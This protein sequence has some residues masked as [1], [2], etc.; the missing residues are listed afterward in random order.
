MSKK[1]ARY[2]S[3]FLAVSILFSGISLQITTAFA[4]E[5]NVTVDGTTDVITDNIDSESKENDS[6]LQDYVAYTAGHKITNKATVDVKLPL[7]AFVADGAE[8]VM[9][10]NVLEWKDGNGKV[11]WT[12]EVTQTAVYNLEFLW[13]APNK[14]IDPEFEILIDG[15]CPFDEAENI[16][17][18]RLWKNKEDKPR[19]DVQGNQYAQEQIEIDD[20]VSTVVRDSEGATVGPFEFALTAGTHTFTIVRPEQ[21]VNLHEITFAKPEV[22]KSYKDVS[23]SYKL[24]NLNTGIITIQ[25]EDA[26]VK[27]SNSIIPK[28]NNSDAG[29]EPHHDYLTKINYIGGTAWQSSGSRLEW[30]FEVEKSGYYYINMRYKQSDLVNGESWRWLKIDGATPFEEAMSLKFPYGTSWEYFT[31][32]KDMGEDEAVK[33]YYIYLDKGPHTISMEVTAGETAEYFHELSEI[34]D[35]L[36]DK[37]MQI[38]MITGESPDLSR[39]YDLDQQIPDFTKVLTECKDR[40]GTLADKMTKGTGQASQ[41]VSAMNNMKRVLENMLRSPYIA[42]QYVTD[43]YS[44]YSSIGS[45]LYDMIRM[46]LSIDE[47]QIIPKGKDYIDKEAGFFS[48]LKFDAV[49]LISSF[50]NDY[51]LTNADKD[52]ENTIRLWV[53]WGQDQA[54]AL[55][56]LIQDSF[57]G[58]KGKEKY[59][60][61]TDGDG[62]GDTPINVQVEIVNASLINGLLAD[63]F[64]DVSLQMART[65]PVNLGIRGALADLSEMPG[66]D[67]TIKQFQSGLTDEQI[68]A[69]S[70]EEFKEVMLTT[71]AVAPYTYNG[72]TYALPDTQNFMLMFYREDIL[73]ELGFDEPPQTWDEFLYYATIIQRKNMSVYVPYTQ[74]TT[75]TTVNAGIGNLHLYPTLMWQHG[76]NIYNEDGNKTMIAGKSELEVF[77]KWTDFYLEY[78]FLKEAD[79]YNRMR[80]GT[81]P[82]GIAPYTTYMTFY[83]TAPEIRGRW[84]IAKVPGV[85]TNGNGVIDVES[86]EGAVAGSGTGCAIIKESTKKE[87]AWAFLKWWTSAETQQRYNENLQSILGMIGRTAVSNKEAFEN[88]AWDKDDLQLLKSQWAE[89]MEVQEVPGSYDV[90]RAI[91]QAFWSVLEDKA[92][93]KDA[94]TKWSKIADR[95]IERKINEYK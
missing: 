3:V 67:E 27:T 7:A 20:V 8:I 49:R 74:I 15:V 24:Q 9:G 45:W 61:D 11:T 53:N 36:G 37:Y 51:S 79:F 19:E 33:P 87:Q 18:S 88:L 48:Q 85:D 54:A 12:F 13:K 68:A 52:D 5:A 2:L 65:E 29:M 57:T 31:F 89:I 50:T 63:N 69:M 80:V 14:G 55:N 25:G 82:L 1:I 38:V 71:G 64:P 91:D 41:A 44:N 34:F 84:K 86:F 59:W 16:V 66:F 77:K 60:R 58:E 43:Y 92:K 47:I 46:P 81:M 28:A 30:N 94:V 73:K 6:D 83:A 22:V 40:L 23:S 35:L 75:S 39:D 32:G 93:V 17:L 4:E 70:D 95:E 62:K 10:E 78:D 21:S 72:K 26:D 42:Q 56:S 90:T 76:L